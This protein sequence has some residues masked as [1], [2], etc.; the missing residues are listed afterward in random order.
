VRGEN[1][2]PTVPPPAAGVHESEFAISVKTI[3]EFASAMT[4]FTT[5]ILSTVEV[6]V[7]VAAGDVQPIGV[8]KTLGLQ[9]APL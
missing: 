2:G 6:G 3:L 8:L 9:L 1:A 5:G 7:T 4:N